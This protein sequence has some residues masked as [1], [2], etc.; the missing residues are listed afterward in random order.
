MDLTR[1][2]YTEAKFALKH[3]RIGPIIFASS[4][5]VRII[6]LLVTRAHWQP[7]TPAEIA[8]VAENLA[9]GKGFS[10]P[11]GC[12]TGPTTHLA[13]V[14]PFLLS[15]IDRVFPSRNSRELAS[16]VLAATFTSLAYAMLPWLATRLGLPK[17]AG[18]LAGL[19][20]AAVPL[21]FW[22]EVTSQKEAPLSALLL[23]VGLG[24]FA[25]LFGRLSISRSLLAGVV[26]GLA[27][28]T[29]PTFLVVLAGLFVALIWHGRRDFAAML[30]PAAVLWLTVIL[31]ILPW[32]IRNYRIFH[33]F[34]PIRGNMGLELYVS[35]NPL[36]GSTLHEDAAL[37]GF[38]GHPYSTSNA[39]EEFAR[40]GE[41]AMNQVYEQKA[42][43]WI[44]ANPMRFSQLVL[45]DFAA[46]WRMA[47]PSPLKTVGS[48]LI[49]LFAALGMWLS[50]KRYRFAALL[51]GIA[52]VTYPLVYYIHFFEPRYRY[53]L[54]PI[55]LLLAG[56]FFTE[57]TSVLRPSSS[58]RR[59]S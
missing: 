2:T 55:C 23:V 30:R 43:E 19:V 31:L 44:R 54:Y 38:S 51:L 48:E 53:P 37:G 42:L 47:V 45:E 33:R 20:G 25:E 18:A 49:T 35:F 59:A 17:R 34:I 28:L 12:T 39:C 15:L 50:I 24:V 40:V 9:A 41:L 57:I 8:L 52:L 29:L 56:V 22:I 32:T 6:L 27:L 36:A 11:F 46:F 14:Y 13:P 10:N 7:V 3:L 58:G 1:I 4:W 21:F 5:T 16:F 26:W